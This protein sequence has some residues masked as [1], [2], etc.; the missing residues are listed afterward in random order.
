MGDEDPYRRALVS[1]NRVK[2]ETIEILKHAFAVGQLQL[3]EYESRIAL[4]ENAQDPE[5]LRGLTLDLRASETFV[6][7]AV[8]DS[9]EI[10]CKMANK[11]LDGT[12]LLTKAITF[13][14][15]MSTIRLDY[16]ELEEL[17]GLKEI[18]VNL[19]MSNLILFLPDDV[20]VE[21]RVQEDM[22]TFKEYRNRYYRS[23]Q[24]RAIIRI[25][26][27]ARMS[28]IKVKRKR[29]SIFSRKGR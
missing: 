1:V 17:R 7:S 28:T 19:N 26:G 25:S 10:T 12:V 8:L 24:P 5:K 14:A 27:S 6:G 9:E 18:I 16:R 2:H 15:S 22:S 23:S 13:E 29:Y 20:I 3:D 4:A 11:R 21:N